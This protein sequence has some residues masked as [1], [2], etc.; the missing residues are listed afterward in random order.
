LCV[1]LLVDRKTC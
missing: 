1:Y